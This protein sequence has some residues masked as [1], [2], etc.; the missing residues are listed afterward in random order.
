MASVGGQRG[1]I[2]DELVSAAMQ[3]SSARHEKK[4]LK[5]SLDAAKSEN[6]E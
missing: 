5:Q 1:G 4:L 6:E 3:I 2:E